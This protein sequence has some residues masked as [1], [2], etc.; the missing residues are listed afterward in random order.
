MTEW[1]CGSM[2][3]IRSSAA[4]YVRFAPVAAGV[5][6]D[7]WRR[8]RERQQCDDQQLTHTTP[9]FAGSA[10]REQRVER[11]LAL[12]DLLQA[13]IA[14]AAVPIELRRCG[15]RRRRGS[16][17]AATAPL[18]AAAL[19]ASLSASP[20]NLRPF[21]AT[22]SEPMVR[23][24]LNAGLSHSTLPTLPSLPTVKPPE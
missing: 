17:A 13:R 16:A 20:S 3:A 23:P 9:L 2:R 4:A 15:R 12:A 1:S 7:G 14:Q 21:T 10:R 11:A 8:M 5:C 22:I 24:A 19:I 18:P 6:A